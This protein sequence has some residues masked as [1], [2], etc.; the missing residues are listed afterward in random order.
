METK[1]KTLAVC[2][3]PHGLR[4]TD[5]RYFR[6]DRDVAEES[7]DECGRP[8]NW[9][10]RPLRGTWVYQCGTTFQLCE[11]CHLAVQGSYRWELLHVPFSGD[12]WGAQ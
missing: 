4:A 9:R 3:N 2:N 7:C 1:I 10:K 12:D 5:F 11:E 6:Y 8:F